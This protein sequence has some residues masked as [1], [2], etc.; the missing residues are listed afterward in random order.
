MF[1]SLS[2]AI[3]IF[4]MLLGVQCLGVERVELNIRQKSAAPPQRQFLFDNTPQV[5]PNVTYTPPSWMPWVLL[6]G[7]AVTCLYSF[8]LSGRGGGE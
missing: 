2:L 7:G 8:T 4:V 5:A 6:G 3:G 1:R